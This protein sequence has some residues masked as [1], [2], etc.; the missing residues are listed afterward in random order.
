MKHVNLENFNHKGLLQATVTN[1]QMF[2][3]ELYKDELPWG[4]QGLPVS[5]FLTNLCTGYVGG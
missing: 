4:N 2:H 3:K 5:K 1:Q